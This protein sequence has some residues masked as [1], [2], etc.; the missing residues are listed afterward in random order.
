MNLEDLATAADRFAVSCADAAEDTA[1]G[2]PGLFA[3]RYS[4]PTAFEATIYNPVLCL[5]LR[6]RKETSVG[7]QSVSFGPGEA[8]IVSH[9]LPV[10]SRVI[11]A[12]PAAPYLALILSLD[13]PVLR[14]LDEELDE[15]DFD[16]GSDQPLQVSAAAEDLVQ[17]LGR[18]LALVE[19][20]IEAR[21]M[22][23]LIHREIHFR[24]L[25]SPNGGM[26]RNLLS[27]NSH[28]SKI[29]KAIAAIR[30]DYRRTLVV[31]DLAQI[32]GMSASS[33]HEHFK[34][35]IGTTP[36]QYQKDL[37]LIEAQQLLR[38]GRHSVAA[39]AFEVGYESPTQFSREYARKFGASP[40]NDI[41]NSLVA[42]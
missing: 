13:I 38:K 40:R 20:P 14:S 15:M 26:L 37:R 33:F 23:P 24:L 30:K 10:T 7:A 3:I 22:A 5:I 41:A 28:A 2:P 27:R 9:D 16:T 32:A 21:V 19:N 31:S 36:L 12:S 1:V 8:L 4:H 34:S 39:A 29:S 25:M 35:I 42:V 17:A 6:G 11:E 18:Y